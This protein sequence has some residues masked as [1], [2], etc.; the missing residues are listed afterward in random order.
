[1]EHFKPIEVTSYDK[2][3]KNSKA[4]VKSTKVAHMRNAE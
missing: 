4:Y 2:I 3:M 1:M